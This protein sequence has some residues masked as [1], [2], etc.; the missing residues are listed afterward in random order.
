[1]AGTFA[2]AIRLD[3]A[4]GFWAWVDRF[5][6]GRVPLLLIALAVLSLG[7]I[8]YRQVRPT[9]PA[10]EI[11]T[12]THI[13]SVEFDDR[14]RQH[15]QGDEIRV[16]NL[17]SAM[18]DRLAIS[19]A[20]QTELP[21]LVEIE[22]S[23]V[24][25]YFRGPVASIPF[26]DLTERIRAEGW[27]ERVVTAR[28]AKYTVDG[29]IFGIPHDIHPVVLVYRPD[30]LAELGYTPDDMATWEGFIEVAQAFYRPGPIGGETWR[31]ALPL[32]TTEAW[33][34]LQLLWQRDGDIFDAEGDVIIDSPLAVDTLEFF[35]RLFE[36]ERPVASPSLTGLPE[37]MR[38]LQQGRFLALLLPDWGLAVMRTL[39]PRD[40]RQLAELVRVAPLPAWE[41][42]GRRTSTVGG[43]AIF[44]P[45]GIDDV[46][47]AWE[48]AKFLY[49]DDE[50]QLTRFRTQSIVPPLKDTYAH[51]VFAKEVAFFQGQRVGALLTELADEVPPVKGSPYLPEAEAILNRMIARVFEADVSAAEALGDAARELETIIARD[52]AAVA[53]ATAEG[54]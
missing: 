21:D 26:V 22:Q 44:I 27:D 16:R 31:R 9:A 37:E 46:D 28:F 47:R 8:G 23:R 38:A 24:G 2:G 35:V 10:C 39:E 11:W 53:Q 14:L 12:F 51:P 42:G 13:S 36:R 30:L 4:R 29:H 52:A 32:K 18:F 1:M 15:P 40:R 3:S 5:P 54:S 45:K 34:F 7:V 19:I 17:G 20:T 43:T 41:P 50:S 49:F 48:L 33:D 6:P 25:R